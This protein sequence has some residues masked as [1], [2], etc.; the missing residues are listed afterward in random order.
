MAGPITEVPL[1]IH[2][3]VVTEN[4]YQS[5]APLYFGTLTEL[6]LHSFRLQFLWTGLRLIKSGF[7]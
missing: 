5:L 6:V 7:L 1:V 4:K 2:S 3:H